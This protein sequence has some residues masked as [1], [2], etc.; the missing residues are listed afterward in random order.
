MLATH[1]FL[2][3]QGRRNGRILMNIL[4]GSHCSSLSQLTKQMHLLFIPLFCDVISSSL[5]IALGAPGR[6][7]YVFT[8]STISLFR[9]GILVRFLGSGLCEPL[10]LLLFI[11]IVLGTLK[12]RVE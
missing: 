6:S 11:R 3:M 10:M 1:R 5:I 8:K 12:L 9:R 4:S 2:V 7:P